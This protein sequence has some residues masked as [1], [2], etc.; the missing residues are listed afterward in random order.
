MSEEVEADYDEGG[1]G[2]EELEAM[3]K[4]LKQMEEEADKLKKIQSQIDNQIGSPGTPILPARAAHDTEAGQITGAGENKDADGRSVF[5]GN[6]SVRHSEQR[7]MQRVV[8]GFGRKLPRLSR[9]R[10]PR[11]IDSACAMIERSPKI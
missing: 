1:E 5:V 6:V 10:Q 7:S 8:L 3:K 9:R 2:A 11:A 4:Q